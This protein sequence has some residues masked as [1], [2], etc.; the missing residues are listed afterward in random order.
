VVRFPGGYVPSRPSD[1]AVLAV[2]AYQVFLD[3]PP[4]DAEISAAIIRAIQEFDRQTH[5][6][7]KAECLD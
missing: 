4:S 2:K 7:E 3:P 5:L 1:I 6:Q